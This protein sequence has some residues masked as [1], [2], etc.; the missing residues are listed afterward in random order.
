MATTK[1]K[2]VFLFGWMSGL[3][4]TMLIMLQ[5][6]WL[7]DMYSR[8]R[9]G[10]QPLAVPADDGYCPPCDVLFSQLETDPASGKLVQ[11]VEMQMRG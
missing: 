3:V 1:T 2:M 11:H 5:L 9:R 7:R 8:D 4:M 10:S 6:G